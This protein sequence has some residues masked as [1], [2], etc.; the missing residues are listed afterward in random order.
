MKIDALFRSCYRTDETTAERP[1]ATYVPLSDMPA[2]SLEQQISQFLVAAPL[3]PC[4]GGGLERQSLLRT[5]NNPENVGCLAEMDRDLLLSLL[6]RLVGDRSCKALVL[7]IVDLVVKRTTHL[8]GLLSCD[9][10]EL[11]EILKS[12]PELFKAIRGIG[13]A[14]M[15]FL[16]QNRH[17]LSQR[18]LTDYL[19]NEDLVAAEDRVWAE[20][21]MPMFQRLSISMLE[22][23]FASLADII[24]PLSSS[25]VRR[26]MHRW[27]HSSP[28]SGHLRYKL[29][30]IEIVR[31]LRTP[32]EEG[33]FRAVCSDRINA[34]ALTGG[35]LDL[36]GLA[37][38][39]LP[40]IFDWTP[41]NLEDVYLNRNRLSSLPSALFLTDIW[42]RIRLYGDR[43]MEGENPFDGARG[44]LSLYRHLSKR[45][46]G[47]GDTKVKILWELLKAIDP[48]ELTFGESYRAV[49]LIIWRWRNEWNRGYHLFA[50]YLVDFYAGANPH[51]LDLRGMDLDSLPDLFHYPQFAGLRCIILDNRRRIRLPSSIDQLKF[52]NPD[53]QIYKGH[54]PPGW[55]AL[56]PAT[57]MEIVALW[58][59]Q[60]GTE[61][62]LSYLNAMADEDQ[63]AVRVWLRKLQTAPD[64]KALPKPFCE[65]VCL[66][67]NHYR[68][69]QE[70]FGLFLAQAKEALGYCGDRASEI[71]N[72]HYVAYRLA[73]CSYE[74]KLDIMVRAAKRSAL[75][76]AIS[77]KVGNHP[78]APEIYLFYTTHP[79]FHPQI[80]TFIKKGLYT[81]R[82]GN[83]PSCRI[84]L[85]YLQ[86]EIDRHYLDQ[87][88]GMGHFVSYLS[89]HPEHGASFIA[90]QKALQEG[91]SERYEAL[92]DEWDK[93]IV[94]EGA[95]REKTVLKYQKNAALDAL[96]SRHEALYAEQRKSFFALLNVV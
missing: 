88:V 49:E 71:L 45:E 83:D 11:L 46:G 15:H 7:Q 95:E 60:A 22:K 30:I 84:T 9:E 68:S 38:R 82:Y 72:D 80:L 20:L 39:S 85:D 31:W 87:L 35:V 65:T 12:D 50:E 34:W 3:L 26:F 64:F 29:V 55:S 6:K 81:E 28:N 91:F 40:Q 75:A 16:G 19:S 17:L 47:E 61:F 73:T 36:S 57:L 90:A 42:G 76:I 52:M 51:S 59:R 53:F 5:L 44:A 89:S 62:D 56:R 93:K 25:E 27:L 54:T 41:A 24:D 13:E 32:A 69:N 43:P 74:E 23:Q 10:K 33:E 21:L 92:S 78:E 96:A 4:F 8:R 79:Q 58:Q 94:A 70:L 63:R 86:Q 14:K 1:V 48:Q 2:S 37:L 67:L 18:L 77:K 66:L